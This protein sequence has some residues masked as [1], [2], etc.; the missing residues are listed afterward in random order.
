MRLR[1]VALT[2]LAVLLAAPVAAAQGRP[3]RV[4][5]RG[6]LNFGT[7][8]PGSVT[9][10]APTDPAGAGEYQ[11]TGPKDVPMQF[12]F[13]LP[14]TMQGPGGAQLVVAFGNGDAGYSPGESI[15]SQ[16][17]FDPRVPTTFALPTNGKASV[18]LGGRALP[19]GTQPAG[20]YTGTVTLIVSQL[21][22]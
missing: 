13:L 15:T 11:V 1:L 2:S 12:S 4:S 20:S 14:T 9:A 16:Q 21:G 22:S 7:L 5:G 3:L 18:F 19:V 6:P 8:L 10:V 17:L